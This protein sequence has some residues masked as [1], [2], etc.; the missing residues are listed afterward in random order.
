MLIHH[1]SWIISYTQ[2]AEHENQEMKQIKA[3]LLRKDAVLKSTLFNKVH[4]VHWK[5]LADQTR[6]KNYTQQ[7]DRQFQKEKMENNNQANKVR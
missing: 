3:S 5:K 7:L 1:H 2:I 4:S 6:Q